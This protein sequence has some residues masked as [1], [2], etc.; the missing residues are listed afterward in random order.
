[1]L[2]FLHTGQAHVATFERLLAKQAPNVAAQHVVDQ[3]LLDDARRDGITPELEQRIE[4]ALRQAFAQGA[5]TVLCTCSSIGG[6]AETIGS[7][8][9][10]PVLRVDR[11]MAARAVALGPRITVAAALA[12]TL[13]PTCQLIEDE[14]RRAGAEVSVSTLLCGDAWPLFEA[15]EHDAYHQ[16]IAACIRAADLSD[17]VVLAQASMAG[18]AQLLSDLDVSVLSSPALGLEAA[19]AAYRSA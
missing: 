4:A 6:S 16:S 11:A 5:T 7:Q 12:S 1:M 8:R 14:A 10:W 9:G 13:E 19:L 18:A 3:A 2:V 17:V 15:G